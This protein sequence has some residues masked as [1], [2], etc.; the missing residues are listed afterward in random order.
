[1][2]LDYYYTCKCGTY[3]IC[4][5]CGNSLGQTTCKYCGHQYHIE[6]KYKDVIC[7]RCGGTG[8]VPGGGPGGGPHPCGCNGGFVRRRYGY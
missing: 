5:K 8:W 3:L 2:R 7:S 1:M 4:G 6:T